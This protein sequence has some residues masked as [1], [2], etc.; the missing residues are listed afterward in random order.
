MATDPAKPIQTPWLE[1]S[2][3]ACLFIGIIT[4]FLMFCIYFTNF[5]NS[6]KKDNFAALDSEGELCFLGYIGVTILA[7]GAAFL[8]GLFWPVIVVSY[9]CMWFAPFI[10]SITAL[11]NPCNCT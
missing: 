3:L 4:G 6:F 11:I 1:L 2:V 7:G 5:T 10:H 9:V 8:C